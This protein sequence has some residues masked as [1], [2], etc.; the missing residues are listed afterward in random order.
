MGF[1]TPW[2]VVRAT[3]STAVAAII[4]VLVGIS[5]VFI[6][7]TVASGR[8]ADQPDS[9]ALLALGGLAGLLVAWFGPGSRSLQRGGRTVVRSLLRGERETGIVIGVL[10]LV[11]V[12]ALLT[13]LGS[14]GPDWS[15]LA[16][17]PL[18]LF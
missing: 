16:Q 7:A 12:A 15:P 3:L 2:H 9:P 18:Q 10:L 14:Q 17:S 8:L 4:P 1:A 5:V 11:A 6:G 13:S